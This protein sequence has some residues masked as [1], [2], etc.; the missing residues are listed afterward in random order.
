MEIIKI[1]RCEVCG[2]I[3]TKKDECKSHECTHYGLTECELSLWKHLCEEVCSS[4][5]E[6]N[7]NSDVASSFLYQKARRDLKSFEENYNLQNVSK[8]A[9]FPTLFMEGAE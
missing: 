2:N 5:A 9:D 7:V 8:P 3:F 1:Y 4:N 6:C